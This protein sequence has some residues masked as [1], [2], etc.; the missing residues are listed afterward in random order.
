MPLMTS[1]GTAMPPPPTA[2]SAGGGSSAAPPTQCPTSTAPPQRVSRQLSNVQR[3]LSA[4]SS[5]ASQGRG[6]TEC[7]MRRLSSSGSLPRPERPGA[8]SRSRTATHQPAA[9]IS[10]RGRDRCARFRSS[11]QTQRQPG[12]RGRSP[13][14][15]KSHKITQYV[16]TVGSI[17]AHSRGTSPPA[18]PLRAS[19]THYLP[20]P[21]AA[22]APAAAAGASAPAAAPAQP[23][24]R[25]A[26][27]PGAGAHGGGASGGS[28]RRRKGPGSP[29]RS[30]AAAEHT[31]SKSPSP[32][33]RKSV[34]PGSA[35]GPAAS[36]LA[37]PSS[38]ASG[39][40]SGEILSP[41]SEPL[42]AGVLRSPRSLSRSGTGS[43]QNR[44]SQSVRWAPRPTVHLLEQS[45]RERRD[46]EVVV[47]G[48]VHDPD[49]PALRDSGGLAAISIVGPEYK[50]C[51]ACGGARKDVVETVR[52]TRTDPQ[53]GL[54]IVCDERMLICEVKSKS[55]AAASGL[56]AGQRVV[57]VDGQPTGSLRDYDDALTRLKDPLRFTVFVIQEPL[58]EEEL[59]GLHEGDA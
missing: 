54:G 45:E 32:G 25:S 14:C 8:V 41:T 20:Q 7:A 29:E 59:Q 4:G 57:A 5:F 27:G 50:R 10:P 55:P 9:P 22:A 53:G 52:I 24:G 37:K 3:T 40:A 21:A 15:L 11:S 13:L 23:R 39:L 17:T 2:R 28:T 38:P 49:C 56:R 51:P 35:A 16:A 48:V 6:E 1:G 46:A 31:N 33:D 34:S 47:A 19:G 18:A 30:A 26:A 12:S 58:T 42:I 43:P 36:P 44:T